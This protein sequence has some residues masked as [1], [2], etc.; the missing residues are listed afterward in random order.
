[1]YAVGAELGRGTER[2][3]VVAALLFAFF[4]WLYLPGANVGLLLMA[5][6]FVI[7]VSAWRTVAREPA[8]LACLMFFAYLVARSVWAV[9]DLPD[10]AGRPRHQIYIW[11]RPL[12]FVLLGFFLA[13]RQPRVAAALVLAATGLLLKLLGHEH[14]LHFASLLTGDLR[15]GFGFRAIQLSLFV[16][17]AILGLLIFAPRLLGSVTSPYIVPRTIAWMAALV[18]LCIVFSATQVRGSWIAAILVVPLVL[19]LRYRP[20]LSSLYDWGIGKRLF[21]AMTVIVLAAT[22]VAGLKGIAA[23]TQAERQALEM[24]AEGQRENV[25]RTSISWRVD[26]QFFGLRKWLERPLLGW[27]PGTVRQLIDPTE[28]PELLH[29][30]RHGVERPFGHL[31]N[32]YLEVLVELGLVGA[33]LLMAI[34]GLVIQ[35]LW[36]AY[37][38]NVVPHDY[39]LFLLGSF[40]MTAIWAAFNFNVPQF[41]WV[42]Y[43][44]LLSGV[45]FGFHLRRRVLEQ[46]DVATTSQ[47]PVSASVS[48]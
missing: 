25:P 41:D 29:P 20:R 16:I 4:A 35:G 47:A 38:R 33:M 43:I 48:K 11:S 2:V 6:A 44:V 32:T 39:A 28:H 26:M 22:T 8:V 36:L 12:L 15:T 9:Y 21:I 40:A 10:L 31:H 24:L 30:D 37:R 17:T 27:G 19:Y 5:G 42:A 3:G 18:I 45:S 46:R 23:R 7:S 14:W 13:G 1:M 34:V